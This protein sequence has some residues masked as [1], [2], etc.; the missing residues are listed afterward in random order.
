MEFSRFLEIVG[1]EPVFETGLLLAGDV[2]PANVRRQLS[3][4]VDA[5][6]LYQLRR[7]VY[8]LAPPFQKVKP[9]PFVVANVLV[10]GSYVSLQSAL[11]H[12]GL[13]PEY[14]PVVTSVTTARPGR[15]ETPL[16]DFGFRHVK[17][18]WLRSYQRLALGGDQRAFVATPEKALLDLV[19]LEPGGDEPTYL[20]EL[21]LQALERLDLDA[22]T[23]LA[24]QSGKPKL[25]RAACRV[26]DLAGIELD[27]Y[28]I[29]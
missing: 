26:A 22:L 13:I 4:W 10:R 16:G 6:R 1:S 15:W 23:R 17:T 19:Y 29:L 2:N 24:D 12:H 9:H 7:G 28:E 18:S 5:G 14:T 8:A 21:R 25:R 20:A 11:A 27:G 3:R